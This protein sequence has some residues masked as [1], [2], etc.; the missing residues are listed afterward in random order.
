MRLMQQRQLKGL[1]EHGNYRPEPELVAQAM[2]R[3]R[4]VRALLTGTEVSAADRIPPDSAA[5]RQAA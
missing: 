2:L 5:R 1:I 3:R 4:S